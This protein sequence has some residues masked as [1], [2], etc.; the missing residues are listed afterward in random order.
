[1]LR[2]VNLLPGTTPEDCAKAVLEA[3]PS[4]KVVHLAGVSPRLDLRDF[5]GRMFDLVGHAEPLAEDAT[6]GTRENQRTGEIW[7]EVRYDPMI[8]DAYR[9]SAN[10]QPLH[11]DGSYIPG[12]PNAGFLACKSMPMTGGATVFVDGS[13]V[14]SALEAE[15]PLLLERLKVTAIPHARSGDRRVEPFLRFRDGEPILNWNYYCVDPEHD[16]DMSDLKEKLFAF[17]KDSP[18]IQA[19]LKRVK[20]SPG[21]AVLWKDDR[22]LHGRDGFNPEVVSDRFLWKAQVQVDA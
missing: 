19:R 10:P 11:T 7:M 6:L 13:D 21:E 20:L 3:W 14:V 1:M 2:T 18:I 17:L 4:C 5:Y 12:F 15:A 8:P 16:S 22:I 9:H